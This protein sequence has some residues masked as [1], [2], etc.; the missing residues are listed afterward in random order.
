MEEEKEDITSNFKLELPTQKRDQSG[1]GS[2]EV[3]EKGLHIFVLSNSL[4]G[5]GKRFRQGRISSQPGTIFSAEICDFHAR[6]V[7]K[8]FNES[9]KLKVHGNAFFFV[10][11]IFF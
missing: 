3:Q 11:T 10:I 9:G 2:A 1:E 7:G 6:C 8:Y 4:A 5:P